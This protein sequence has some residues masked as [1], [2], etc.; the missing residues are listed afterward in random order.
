M[1]FDLVLKN[2]VEQKCGTAMAAPVATALQYNSHPGVIIM[3][4]QIADIIHKRNID[5]NIF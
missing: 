3:L 2:W 1:P 5:P 4:G